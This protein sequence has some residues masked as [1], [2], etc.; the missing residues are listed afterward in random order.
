MGASSKAAGNSTLPEVEDSMDPSHVV[1][2]VGL[3]FAEKRRSRQLAEAAA[4]QDQIN[5][6]LFGWESAA[7]QLTVGV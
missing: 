3:R 1:A 4:H 5:P 7:V 6:S 2:T